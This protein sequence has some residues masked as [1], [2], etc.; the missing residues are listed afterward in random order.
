MMSTIYLNA[1]SINL[2]A[3]HIN[4]MTHLKIG[5]ITRTGIR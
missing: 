3:Q 2:N 5:K 4:G 1:F